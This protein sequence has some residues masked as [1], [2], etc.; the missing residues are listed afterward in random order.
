M[1]TYDY[2]CHDC[3]VVMEKIH[4]MDEEPI[5]ECPDCGRPMV[6]T[7]TLGHG[8]IKVSDPSW[9]QDVNGYINDLERVN[10]G[11]EE[12][13]TT[14]EQARRK[15]AELYADPY[16]APMNNQELAANKRVATL[17][18]RYTERF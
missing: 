14:R 16:P 10:S 13:I 5:F 15:I 11:K 6:K 18:Q 8:G 17:R 7:I 9:V 2:C 1:P 4:K 3:R 12:R